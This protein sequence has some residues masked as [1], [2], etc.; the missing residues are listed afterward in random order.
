MLLSLSWKNIWRNKTR[1]LIIIFAIVFG[2]IGGVGFIAFM[3]GMLFQRLDMAIGNEV[4]NIQIHNPHFQ[5]NKEVN[6]TMAGLASLTQTLDTCK[7]IKAFSV[8]LKSVS[9]IKSANSSDGIM[10]NGVNP[11]KE[12][13]VTNI[14]KHLVMG[15]YLSSKRKNGILLGEKLVQKLKVKLR[16]KVVVTMQTSSGN[17]TDAAYK[18][19]GVFRTGNSTFDEHN[20]YV[21]KDD[22]AGIIGFTD[23]TA[24]EIAVAVYDDASSDAVVAAL[25]KANHTSN[26]NIQTWKEVMPE[27]GYMTGVLDYML[28][29]FMTIIFLALSFGIINTML[30]AVL[31]RLR[32]IGMLMAIGMNKTK[33]FL[34]IMLETTLLMFTGSIIG[35]ILSYIL[36]QFYSKHGID[37]SAF[38]RGMSSMGFSSVIYPVIDT[39]SYLKIVVMVAITGIL[40][41][42]VPARKSLS[43]NPSEAIRKL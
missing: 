33:I 37:L 22:L 42:I 3:N 7:K 30:M 1:S 38:A 23:Q 16:S 35:L 18:V 5:I 32:E 2:V 27:L 20:A 43:L 4:S 36:I 13:Q 26:L 11:E 21:L 28:Y 8:R 24:H 39:A 17:I 12:R 29:I 19:V 40:S 34:M 15:E 25:K 6:D 41:S 31:D 9:M 10:L 14:S